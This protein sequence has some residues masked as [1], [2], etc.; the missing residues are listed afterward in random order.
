MRI[1]KADVILIALLLLAGLGLWLFSFFSSSPGDTVTVTVDGT[2]YG[3]YPLNEEKEVEIR[4][5]EQLN[6]LV[7]RDNGVQ[8]AEAN[9]TGQECVH[10]G[11]ITKNGSIICLP[12]RV[13]AEI[14]SNRSDYDAI[15]S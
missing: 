3:S 12:H 2:F 9:C 6:R 1:K 4:Q 7:I 11:R 8:M 15:V 5:G 10:Q 14:T 13:V